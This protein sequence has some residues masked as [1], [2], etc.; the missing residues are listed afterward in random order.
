MSQKGIVSETDSRV[1]RPRSKCSCRSFRMT[2]PSLVA[3]TTP[4]SSTPAA[5]AAW[6]VTIDM[7][8]PVKALL[9]IPY[10]CAFEHWS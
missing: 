5:I 8:S 3:T 7:P 2:T 9:R 10:G 4:F 6:P 1:F